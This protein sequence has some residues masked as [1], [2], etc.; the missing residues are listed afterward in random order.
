MGAGSGF[1][2]NRYQDP[3]ADTAASFVN[4]A[5]WFYRLGTPQL[6]DRQ[7]LV[8][9]LRPELVRPFYR[10]NGGRYFIIHSMSGVGAMRF[11]WSTLKAPTGSRTLRGAARRLPGRTRDG[12]WTS[13]TNKSRSERSSRF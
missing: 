5:V 12:R 3:V 9:P 1:F 6:K 11:R 13:S 2:Y 4:H 8:T 10:S 7:I